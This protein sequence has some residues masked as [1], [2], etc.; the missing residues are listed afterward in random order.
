[1][2][3]ALR[4]SAA[5]ALIG[6][7]A[8]GLTAEP[9]ARQVTA[10]IFHRQKIPI[11]SGEIFVFKVTCPPGYVAVAG[12][13]FPLPFDVTLLKSLPRG[14]E[15]IFAFEPAGYGETEVV[16]VVTCTKRRF[17]VVR[18]GIGLPVRVRVGNVRTR[19]IQVPV[20]ESTERKVTCPGGQAPAGPSI[21]VAPSGGGGS[22][23]PRAAAATVPRILPYK[24]K[25]VRGGRENGVE[26]V[27]GPPGGVVLGETC[28]GRR[29]CGR[30]PSGERVCVPV[31]I[32]RR[33][34]EESVNPGAFGAEHSCRSGTAPLHAGFETVPGSR[35]RPLASH[36]DRGRKARWLYANGDTSAGSAVSHLLCIAGRFR[37]L[38][39]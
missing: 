23:G 9:A 20:G 33:S 30:A 18:G 3:R 12:T 38:L 24:S 36:P 13:T 19:R 7:A 17:R 39:R 29:A 26:H 5:A 4:L 35:V 34:F 10:K 22:L 27:E 15:R 37:D 28:I 6:I 21:D 14:R 31:T 11:R 32:T 2:A 16:V 1:M 25:P 8:A